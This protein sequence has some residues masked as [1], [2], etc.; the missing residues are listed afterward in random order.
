M[1]SAIKSFHGLQQFLEDPDHDDK[2]YLLGC[3]RTVP[4]AATVARMR[5]LLPQ[6]GITRIA[7]VTGLDRIG[8]PVVMVCRPNARSLAVSQGKGLDLAAATA[9]GLM[10]A[11]ELY[12]AEHVELPLKLMSQRELGA[13][14]TLVDIDRLPRVAGGRFNP[15]L[16]MLWIEGL[17]L[18]SGQPRWLPFECV[19]TN[20]TL[21][22]PPGSGCF[23][24]SSNGLASGNTL[25]EAVSH[26]I[27]E[28][29]ERDATAI[30]NQSAGEARRQ[31]GLD[32]ETVDDTACRQVLERLERAEFDVAV[33]D[34]TGDVG[35]PAFFCL[36]IDRRSRHGHCG[37]GAG[38]HPAREI[39]LLRALTEAV[40]V[41]TTYISGTRD[42]LLPEDYGE[43]EKARKR[44][45]AEGL[46]RDHS[47]IRSL[48]DVADLS[49]QSISTDLSRLLDR[50]KGAGI[51]EVLVVDLTKARFD[52]PVVRVVIPG[53]EGPDDHDAYV[54]GE[55]ARRRCGKCP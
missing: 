1:V 40:Q 12:H 35:V 2:K 41:R 36:I 8:V 4:P 39:A 11:V 51:D 46:L 22:P 26:G 42:D 5:A 29:I 21:P 17:D 50:L 38:T 19:R 48:A 34:T 28:V 45:L 9:S 31:S 52:V 16:V 24:C 14:H 54:P 27:C 47:P 23:D 3:H 13:S 7:N 6:M 15:D 20:F 55:R 43:A 53:L 30:W 44:Q 25:G 49:S 33:W 10:E 18:V 37:I 32:L